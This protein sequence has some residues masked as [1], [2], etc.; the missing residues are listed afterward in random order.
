MRLYLKSI[1]LKKEKHTC[2]ADNRRKTN[3]VL[4]SYIG[5]DGHEYRKSFESYNIPNIPKEGTHEYLNAIKLQF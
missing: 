4:A 2:I 5:E 1:I 3:Y